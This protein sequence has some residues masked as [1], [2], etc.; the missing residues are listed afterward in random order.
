[1][2]EGGREGQ[3]KTKGVGRTWQEGRASCSCGR[4]IIERPDE[5][6]GGEGII[7]EPNYMKFKYTYILNKRMS[8][9]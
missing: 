2:Q 3:C 4:R 9:K 6:L 7:P 5:S 8:E 1:M